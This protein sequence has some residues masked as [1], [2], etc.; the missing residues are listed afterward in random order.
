M[1]NFFRTSGW[2]SCWPRQFSVRTACV[3]EIPGTDV[4]ARSVAG[5]DPFP[6]NRLNLRDGWK[7][8]VNLVHP[9]FLRSETGKTIVVR[10]RY[11]PVA[12]RMKSTHGSHAVQ[13]VMVQFVHNFLQSHY[14]VMREWSR[15]GR[16]QYPGNQR[17]FSW[18]L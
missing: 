17:E 1:T 10:M 16:C 12:D 18:T 6:K 8:R 14:V 4:R 9:G 5:Q 15:L 3:R 7:A 13:G 2:R 11:S